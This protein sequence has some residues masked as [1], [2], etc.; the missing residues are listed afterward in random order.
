MSRYSNYNYH[1]R[2]Y[3]RLSNLSTPQPTPQSR[4]SG[5][6]RTT[7]FNMTNSWISD[8]QPRRSVRDSTLSR[9]I[10]H[11]RN[12][13]LSN[14]SYARS[15]FKPRDSLSEKY[16]NVDNGA[17]GSYIRS[18]NDY[19]SRHQERSSIR[20]R[21]SD[22]ENEYK[23]Y[24]NDIDYIGQYGDYGETNKDYNQPN[25]ENDGGDIWFDKPEILKEKPVSL[26]LNG[27]D[28]AV[29]QAKET[30]L[31]NIGNSCYM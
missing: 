10:D 5:L 30:G 29:D 28:V 8:H 15:E 24:R 22:H 1:N 2:D 3:H 6:N 11:T 13:R 14:L 7:G 26:D 12:S 20:S 4:L 25:Q 27:I 19:I 18:K 16:Q 17:S 23:A 21:D 9:D 31:R